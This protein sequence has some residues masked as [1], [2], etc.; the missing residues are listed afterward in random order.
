MTMYGKSI[1]V[2]GGSVP[3]KKSKCTSIGPGGQ[4]SNNVSFTTS[5]GYENNRTKGLRTDYQMSASANNS[6]A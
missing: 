2:G 6:K 1:G 4:A 3:A 5:R